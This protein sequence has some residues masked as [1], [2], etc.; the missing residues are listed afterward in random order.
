MV[1]HEVEVVNLQA[2][3]PCEYGTIDREEMER[4]YRSLGVFKGEKCLV[5][6]IIPD[7]N[8]QVRRFFD[9]TRGLL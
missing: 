4:F 6:H 8:V 3:L 9:W 1:C 2:I 5:S 7:I